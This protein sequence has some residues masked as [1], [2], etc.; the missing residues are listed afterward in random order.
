[1]SDCVIVKVLL[2]CILL[3]LDE[4]MSTSI[5]L[6]NTFMFYDYLVNRYQITVTI[7]S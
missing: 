1:M 5:S 3:K 7:I 4:T 2:M 6:R